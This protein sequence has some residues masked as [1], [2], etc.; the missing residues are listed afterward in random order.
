MYAQLRHEIRTL[1]GK[2]QVGSRMWVVLSGYMSACLY[3]TVGYCG[4][5]RE[6]L[7]RLCGYDS[8]I[9]TCRM[10]QLICMYAVLAVHIQ[11]ILDLFIEIDFWRQRLRSTI[12]STSLGKRFFACRFIFSENILFWLTI[13]YQKPFSVSVFW[14][15]ICTLKLNLRPKIGPTYAI[16]VVRWFLEFLIKNFFLSFIPEFKLSVFHNNI[17]YISEKSNMQDLLKISFQVT[18]PKYFCIVCLHFYY[19][20]KWKYL[21]I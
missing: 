21:I 7:I 4:I 10:L 8:A 16:S 18:Y 20:R 13:S 17:V 3:K 5:D 15:Q 14:S 6:A 1:I 11:Q 2:Y 12:L 9:K 19:G